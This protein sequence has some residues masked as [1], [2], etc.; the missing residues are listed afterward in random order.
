MRKSSFENAGNRE[1]ID[2]S[3]SREIA[4]K[5]D[6]VKVVSDNMD[7]V[8]VVST[9]S[10]DGTLDDVIA[11]GAA[12]D[13]IVN[14]V[15][16]TGAAGT[17]VIWD[18]VAGEITVPRGDTGPEGPIST[19]A[20]PD[21]PVGPQG[22]QGEVGLTGA[23]SVVAGPQGIQGVAGPDGPQGNIGVTGAEGPQ[24]IQGV[25][26]DIGLTG[27]QGIQGIQG[28]KGDT[29]DQGVLGKG[30]DT[31]IS[32]K[33][34]DTTTV[35]V[36]GTFDN[37]PEIFL[38]ADGVDGAG[39]GDMLKATYDTSN[40]GVVDNA[41]LVNGLSVQ[42]AVPA[43]ALFTDTDTVYDDT[44][45]SAA[46]ALNTAK[47]S[48]VDHPLVETAVPAGAVF[49]DTVYDDSLVLKDSDI[50]TAV[51][52]PTGDGSGLTGIDALPD[53]TG[54]S[55]KYLT[56][57]GTLASWGDVVGSEHYNQNTPPTATA[58]GATWFNIDTGVLYKWVS[59]GVTDV[60]VDISTAGS[61]VSKGYVDGTFL[62]PTG[63][64]SGLSG[65]DSLPAQSGHS[66]EVLST[67]GTIASWIAA[68][69]GGDVTTPPTI[70]IATSIAENATVQG[71][72]DDFSDLVEYFITATK[73]T[74]SNFNS[75]TGSF[76]FKAH[77]ILSE[78]NETD[79]ISIYYK[80]ATILTESNVTDLT[81]VLLVISA[82]TAIV[83]SDFATNELYNEGFS[84]A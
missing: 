48:N 8:V 5:Y 81:I 50:G 56:T 9:M 22:I 3:L 7:D 37:S 53:Q 77:D 14:M 31:V 39:A 66:G 44:T 21:G 72:I 24:G 60:W 42:T 26:G 20:G 41:E 43:G 33:V 73:G 6:D 62:T 68:P 40:N 75:A 11:A 34:G 4:S 1:A 80:M 49:T 10:T 64:G 51:L 74:I 25:Q 67:D 30:I 2:V 71:Q 61:G 18:G 78:A 84:H 16:L 79:Q 46:V 17:D 27:I 76:S 58:T 59:D 35:T 47:V 45:I 36:T 70:T 57:N 83:N 55:G 69:T 15:A 19:V 32:S 12:V 63:D 29:G 52:A 13:A 65:V 38:V 54:S 82:D 28:V 23:D